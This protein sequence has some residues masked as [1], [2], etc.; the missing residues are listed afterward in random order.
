MAFYMH[1]F[2]HQ[3]VSRKRSNGYVRHNVGRQN[4]RR[5][6]QTDG[7]RGQSRARAI[8]ISQLRDVLEAHVLADVLQQVFQ[9]GIVQ[10]AGPAQRQRQS[11]CSPSKRRPA[12]RFPR[13]RITKGSP[14]PLEDNPWKTMVLVAD[15]GQS[16]LGSIRISE[17]EALPRIS[18]G[19]QRPHRR[20]VAGRDRRTA[21]RRRGPTH[22][23]PMANRPA[24]IPRI[25]GRRWQ[26][27]TTNTQ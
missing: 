22:S 10:R 13:P 27:A 23:R 4:D 17:V 5:A 1:R 8:P 26:V 14:L 20:A 9:R 24:S 18:P 15:S 12:R 6:K 11:A 19:R 3:C 25:L 16:S 21:D 2:V 7:Y